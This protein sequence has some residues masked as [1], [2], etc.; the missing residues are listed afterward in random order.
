[1]EA[2]GA[3]AFAEFD[4]ATGTGIVFDPYSEFVA[5][6]KQ[7]PVWE[8]KLGLHFGL[9]E[10]TIPG[11]EEHRHF[12]ALSY[13][14]VSQVLLDGNTF[15]SKGYA[16][17]MGLVMG[18]S[19]LEMDE[20]EHRTYRDL[21][22]HA[23]T[24]KAMER[25]RDR[26]VEPIIDQ[27]ISAIADR[28]RAE[29]VRDVTFPFPIQVIAQMLGLPEEDLPEFHRL[30]V[31][32]IAIAT[33]IERGFAASQSLRDYFAGIVGERRASPGND[34][35]SMLVT[36]EIDGKRLT[37][38]EIFA[39]L[40][41]LLPAGAETTYRSSSNLLAGLLGNPAQLAALI[42]DRSLMKQAIEEGLRWEPP[43]TT[44]VRTATREVDICG[45]TI[46]ESAQVTACLGAA[47]H[48]PGRWENPHTFDI[49]RKPRAHMAFATGTHTCLGM[50]LA[51]METES[52]LNAL[53]DRLPNLRLD[54]DAD[55]KATEISGLMFRAPKSLPV[56]FG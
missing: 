46:P 16:N 10:M 23:F 12:V 45:V 2:A 9:N 48:D 1:M 49:F 17:S 38:E 42:E 19:I 52:L 40:R 30:A 43:L 20:P 5:L 33:N 35:I 44:I 13:E 11:T 50:H 14:A 22:K 27:R 31:E 24:L 7:T 56:V 37:D 6:M 4:E 47:N 34:L 21:L 54:P 15:S 29:L 36:A 25:W 28:G 41:L 32:L 53:F 51:R 8:G 18:H 55:P 26:V 39:F 3:N